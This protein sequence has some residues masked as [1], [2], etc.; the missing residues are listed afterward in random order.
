MDS[1]HIVFVTDGT[2][3][4]SVR[5]AIRSALANAGGGGPLTVSVVY[6]R[7]RVSV[8]EAAKFTDLGGNVRLVPVTNRHR[9]KLHSC[10]HYSHAM[11]LK[12]DLPDLLPDLDKVLY[13][14][15]DVIVSGDVRELYAT[16]LTGHYAAVVENPLGYDVGKYVRNQLH[17][18]GRYWNSGVMLLNLDAMR[19][20]AYTNV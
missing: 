19:R 18:T 2:F 10:A 20:E 3:T 4:L 5:A 7:D 6:D 11:Y 9:D 15:G 17:F 1:L 13:L 14:D 12:Y 16:D 8:S